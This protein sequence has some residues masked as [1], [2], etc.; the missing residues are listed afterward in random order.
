[1]PL[2]KSWSRNSSRTFSGLCDRC[3]VIGCMRHA[4]RAE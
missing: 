4:E 3:N 1:V 2:R